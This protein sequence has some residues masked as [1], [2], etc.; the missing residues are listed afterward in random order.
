[1]TI[2]RRLSATYEVL[3]NLY[4]DLWYKS[5][6]FMS[7]ILNTISIYGLPI[8]FFI[9]ITLVAA[10]GFLVQSEYVKIEQYLLNEEASYIRQFALGL[11]GALIGSTAI[12]ASLVLFS[13]QVN[14]ERLPHAMF[15]SLS[16]DKN[17]FSMFFAS[18]LIG[19]LILLSPIIFRD[20]DLWILWISVSGLMINIVIYFMTYQR[21]LFLIN[22]SEQVRTIVQS[23]AKEFKRWS[24]HARRLRHSYARGIP[25]A[26][27]VNAISTRNNLAIWSFYRA[28][29]RWSEKAKISTNHIISMARRAAEAGD[30]QISGIA[31]KGILSIH[32]RHIQEFSTLFDVRGYIINGHLNAAGFVTYTLEQFRQITAAAISRRDEQGISQAFEAVADLAILYASVERLGQTG[33]GNEATLA[34]GYLT[35]DVRRVVPQGFTDVAMLGVRQIGRVGK[36]FIL[37]LKILSLHGPVDALKQIALKG[38]VEGLKDEI[39]FAVTGEA[40]KELSELFILTL[41]SNQ[42]DIRYTIDEIQKAVGSIAALV[43]VSPNPQFS[44]RH[45]SLLGAF[46]GGLG[47]GG[48]LTAVDEFIAS[49]ERPGADI[50]RNL[51]ILRRLSEWTDGLAVSQRNLLKASCENNSEFAP[52]LADWMIGLTRLIMRASTLASDEGRLQSALRKNAIWLA[53]G[54]TWITDDPRAVARIETFQ[55]TDKLFDLVRQAS[56]FGFEPDEISRYVDLLLSW[57]VKAGREPNGWAILEKGL[58]AAIVISHSIGVQREFAE[59]IST[60]VAEHGPISSGERTSVVREL[61]RSADRH[62]EARYSSSLIERALS[63]LPSETARRMLLEVADILAASGR[64]EPNRKVDQAD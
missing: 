41:A 11:G 59:L 14:V 22:P 21:S 49:L 20:K 47:T 64:D 52:D 17:L 44:G 29:E 55:V 45:S 60:A 58:K 16:L 39:H 57:T 61:R 34:S 8:L 50:E 2:K 62:G 7:R 48:V 19:A 28:N 54:V 18:F 13:M 43:I 36:A 30:Y 12:V 51:Q 6:G 33:T 63:E 25:L 27:D 40:V 5:Y 9:V 3:R 15:R 37:K 35:G 24:A 42:P 56:A 32:A 26:D 1:M 10:S 4:I 31:L 46:Y 38:I 53:F 23:N